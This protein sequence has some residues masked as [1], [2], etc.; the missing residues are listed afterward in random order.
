MV[1]NPRL[2]RAKGRK[3]MAQ[4][5]SWPSVVVGVI[6]LLFGIVIMAFGV[7][8]SLQ[9]MS[10]TLLSVCLMLVSLLFFVLSAALLRSRR[11][12]LE[13]ASIAYIFLGFCL[14]FLVLIPSGALES[15]P[16]WDVV[17]VATVFTMPFGVALIA[18]YGIWVIV[19]KRQVAEN[20]RVFRTLVMSVGCVL[21]LPL[22]VAAGMYG[23]NRIGHGV[24]F[25]FAFAYR[26]S[27]VNM[28]NNKQTLV[29]A[30]NTTPDE[31]IK[32]FS[33]ATSITTSFSLP[34]VLS[35]IGPY[36]TVTITDQGYKYTALFCDQSSAGCKS[37]LTK[38]SPFD[39]SVYA[40]K[41]VVTMDNKT[42]QF[43]RS[44]SK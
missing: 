33:N 20:R 16:T 38:G 29:Y 42:Y 30:T 3:E 35:G 4:D 25:G 26:E 34:N 15:S 44:R 5:S 6:S 28:D 13:C 31:L 1:K 18:Y 40:K 27:L 9:H 22:V 32:K 37:L 23:N 39:R 14:W 2:L 17:V 8:S 36:T 19:K 12:A 43:L 41:Y 7:Y 10:P 21:L 24:G 11:R